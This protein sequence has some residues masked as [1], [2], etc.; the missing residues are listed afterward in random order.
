M[1]FYNK[2]YIDQGDTAISR[3]IES[4]A[5][6]ID[7]KRA[8]P[9][10]MEDTFQKRTSV[11]IMV[12]DIAGR[13]RLG[14]G[15][16]PSRENIDETRISAAHEQMLRELAEDDGQDE[17][18][19]EWFEKEFAE[20]L[21]LVNS[22]D[23]GVNPEGESLADAYIR[24]RKASLSEDDN[25]TNNERRRG[26]RTASL[27]RE[28]S[29]RL[30]DMLKT[31]RAERFVL[32]REGGIPRNLPLLLEG[33]TDSEDESPDPTPTPT[34]AEGDWHGSSKDSTITSPRRR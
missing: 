1:K 29:K 17:E 13:K 16:V 12:H 20:D 5:L 25:G 18:L 30:G 4:A 15:N 14:N 19:S 2:H 22:S 34:D 10:F 24:E 6:R 11:R 3:G 31:E 33:A 9:G 32:K 26:S 28:G 27:I 7:E 8:V 23:N 21:G